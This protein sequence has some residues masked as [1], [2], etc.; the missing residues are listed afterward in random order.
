MIQQLISN[1]VT[2]LNT[3]LNRELGEQIN[4]SQIITIPLSYI[5]NKDLPQIGICP[6]KLIINHK[7]KDIGSPQP[8]IQEKIQEIDGLCINKPYELEYSPITVIQFFE[9]VNSE[10]KPL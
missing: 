6:G 2:E 4:N 10:N 5:T 8:T 7:L 3:E 1:I 9:R